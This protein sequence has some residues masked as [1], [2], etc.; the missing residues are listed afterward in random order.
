MF[1]KGDILIRLKSY[2]SYLKKGLSPFMQI[3]VY[4]FKFKLKQDPPAVWNSSRE[5]KENE[6]PSHFLNLRD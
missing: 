5:Q 4:Q 6:A 1:D 2:A 3:P